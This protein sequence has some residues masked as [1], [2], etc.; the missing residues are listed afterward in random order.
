MML[1]TIALVLGMAVL[2]YAITKLFESAEDLRE[3]KA[4]DYWRDAY[5]QLQDDLS[6]Y[7]QHD[8]ACQTT[9][10]GGTCDCGYLEALR[11]E[12]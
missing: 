10:K 9:I 8:P 6:Y 2:L 11:R 5:E 3:Q 12:P 4:I 7:G 1:L